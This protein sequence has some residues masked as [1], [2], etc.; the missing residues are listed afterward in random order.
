MRAPPACG[1]ATS[2]SDP[3]RRG[4]PCSALE[5]ARPGAKAHLARGELDE[6]SAARRATMPRLLPRDLARP[7]RRRVLLPRCTRKAMVRERCTSRGAKWAKVPDA[8]VLRD[9]SENLGHGPAEG[10][11]ALEDERHENCILAL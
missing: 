11:R 1:E 6:E 5:A 7:S 10:T 9:L 3:A 8:A 2:P 4:P